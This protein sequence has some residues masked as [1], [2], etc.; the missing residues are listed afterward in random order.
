MP[1]GGGQPSAD[2]SAVSTGTGT[3]K[4]TGCTVW[5]NDGHGVSGTV[6]SGGGNFVFNSSTTS[7]GWFAW[8]VDNVY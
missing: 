2:S 3:I 5:G 7:T 1:V 4:F 6:V 8:P